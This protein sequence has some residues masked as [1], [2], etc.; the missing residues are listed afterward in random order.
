MKRSDTIE[1]VLKSKDN[2]ALVIQAA[3]Q[4]QKA[5]DLILDRKPEEM[6]AAA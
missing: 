4:A 6:K 3:S 2:K 5:V 1:L